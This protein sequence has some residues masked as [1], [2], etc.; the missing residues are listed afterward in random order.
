MNEDEMVGWHHWLHGRESEQAPG[1]GVGQ[2]SLVWCI[3]WGCEES[4]MTDQL[5]N[6]SSWFQRYAS[7]LSFSKWKYQFLLHFHCDIYHSLSSLSKNYFIPSYFSSLAGS[8]GKE[9]A[10]NAGL[11]VVVAQP[12]LTLCDPW[13]IACQAPLSME[14]FRQ[15]YWSG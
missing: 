8:D 10:C 15:F 6:K 3:P 7:S 5:N 13:T 1:D 12:F 14:F 11:K 9:P 4:D 2:E